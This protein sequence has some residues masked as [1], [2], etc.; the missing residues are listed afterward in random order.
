MKNVFEN[1]RA[2]ASTKSTVLL[3]GE[4]GTGKGFTARFIHTL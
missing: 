1:I 3:L 4:T 2:V